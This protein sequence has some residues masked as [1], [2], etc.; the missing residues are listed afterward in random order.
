MVPGDTLADTASVV[1]EFGRNGGLEVLIN[2]F[3]HLL[4]LVRFLFS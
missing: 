1:Q 4:D 2:F 3:L